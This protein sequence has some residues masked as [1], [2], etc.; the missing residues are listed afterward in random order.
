MT[1]STQELQIALTNE[2]NLENTVY[3]LGQDVIFYGSELQCFKMAYTMKS[4]ENKVGYSKNLNTWY[5]SF[6][7]WF[8]VE[9][10]QNII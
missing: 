7:Y 2:F 3:P 8:D 1:I 5:V 6:P 9:F 10:S 4:L